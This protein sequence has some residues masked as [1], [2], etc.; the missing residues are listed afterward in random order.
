M[1]IR[2]TASAAGALLLLAA[3]FAGEAG[4]SPGKGIGRAQ[5]ILS[6]FGALLLLA[7]LLG[8]RFWTFY[9][10]LGKVTF[11]AFL[12]FAC[13]ELASAFLIRLGVGSHV[14]EGF[15]L[16][17]DCGLDPGY[18]P[19]VAWRGR[20]PDSVAGPGLLL[21]GG[22]E[23]A[24]PPQDNGGS[25]L[26]SALDSILSCQGGFGVFD[27]S[28][29]YYSSPQSLIALVLELRGGIRPSDVLIVSGPGDVLTGLAT[30]DPAIFLGTDAFRALTWNGTDGV[31]TLSELQGRAASRKACLL[32]LTALMRGSGDERVFGYEPLL[33]LPDVSSGEL[34]RRAGIIAERIGTCC[35]SLEALSSGFSFRAKVVWIGLH[36]DTDHSSSVLFELHMRTDSLVKALADSLPNLAVVEFLPSAQPG[37]T[38]S[39]YSGFDAAQS[40]ELAGSIV[41]LVR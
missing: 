10:M 22:S 5:L 27:H 41:E 6:L 21:L 1:T 40:R 39:G 28:Q 31:L 11:S 4:L 2:T 19:F 23:L 18:Q 33:A 36:P 29:P 7:G 32:S 13:L 15:V 20:E 30:G 25:I 9:R 14:S 3:L 37:E 38:G 26:V 17:F 35:T 34:D 12:A 24:L 8:N 16:R